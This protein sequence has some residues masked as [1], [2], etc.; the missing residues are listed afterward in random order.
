MGCGPSTPA[1]ADSGVTSFDFSRR[2]TLV[3]KPDVAV[4]IG[5]GVKK[6]N[7]DYRVVFIFGES[8]TKDLVFLHLYSVKYFGYD[9]LFDRFDP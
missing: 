1:Q 6:L 3:K 9:L 4:E 8:F 2:N 7:K 5:E